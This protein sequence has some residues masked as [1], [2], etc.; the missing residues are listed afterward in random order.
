MSPT[1]IYEESSG[2]R[3]VAGGWFRDP[4]TSEPR[5]ITAA[6]LLPP[7]P[8]RTPGPLRTFPPDAAPRFRLAADGAPFARVL[9]A[10]LHRAHGGVRSADACVAAPLADVD[11]AFTRVAPPRVGMRVA[12]RRPRGPVVEGTVVSIDYRSGWFDSR[13]DL[14]IEVADGAPFGGAGDSGALVVGRDGAAVGLYFGTLRRAAIG[15]RALALA[16]G[17]HRL[18]DVLALFG[19]EEGR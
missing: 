15:G 6:H 17:A 14:V 10:G 9:A 7:P 2:R 12:L 11:L 16:G 5:L 3:G 18:D 4:A 19:L 8:A 13:R 1:D